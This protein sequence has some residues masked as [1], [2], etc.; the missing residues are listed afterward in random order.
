MLSWTDTCGTMHTPEKVS[1]SDANWGTT[2]A[3]AGQQVLKLD[4]KTTDAEFWQMLDFDFL[5]GRPYNAAEVRSAA[6]VVVITAGHQPA[7][8]RYHGQ[9]RSG[10]RHGA[11]GCALPRGGRG[12]RRAHCT[13]A[14]TYAELW[15]PVTTGTNNLRDP[16]YQGRYQAILLARRPADVP[17]LKDEYQQHHRA[18]CRCPTPSSSSKINSYAQTVLA[19]AH[20]AVQQ[21][22]RGR[23]RRGPLCPA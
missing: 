1:I 5:A 18:A 8:L 4:S 3:Y 14:N 21:R 2:V 7:L 6:H 20:G 19:V 10:P 9:G 16:S 15:T 17:L 23:G 11:G 12:A 22:C 13:R